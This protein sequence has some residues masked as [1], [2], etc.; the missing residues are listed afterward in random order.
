MKTFLLMHHPGDIF[1]WI[2]FLLLMRVSFY[3]CFL[4][5]GIMNFSTV[6]G[7]PKQGTFTLLIDF[8]VGASCFVLF[9]H[10]RNNEL[11]HSAEITGTI[12]FPFDPRQLEP[13]I[14]PLILDYRNKDLFYWS[15]T[16]GKIKF[17]T[18]FQFSYVY[19]LFYIDVPWLSNGCELF[20]IVSWPLK[21]WNF[22]L[23]L[24]F[25]YE[26]NWFY[27]VPRF[28]YGCELFYI[29]PLLPEQWTLP[30]FLDNRKRNFTF[31]LDSLMARVVIHC[32]STLLLYIRSIECLHRNV[33][34]KKI[35]ISIVDRNTTLETIRGI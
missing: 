4:T 28:S 27:I 17:Y 31:F 12:D 6:P 35:I 14:F 20:H 19:E 11:V 10:H 30:I 33:F 8:H 7:P 18:V 15:S 32:S 29:L 13:W 1:R 21:Q 23:S 3:Y 16:T 24:R 25:S 34:F 2:V 22:T 26:S 5:T 9:L